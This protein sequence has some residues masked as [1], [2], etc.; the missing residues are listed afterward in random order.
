LRQEEVV[1]KAEAKREAEEA[2]AAKLE[3]EPEETKCKA[4]AA[5]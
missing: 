3:A 5:Y 4:E 2:R 1:C